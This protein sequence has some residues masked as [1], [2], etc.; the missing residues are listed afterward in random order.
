[1]EGLDL[2]WSHKRFPEEA[3]KLIHTFYVLYIIIGRCRSTGIDL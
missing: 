1:M 2:L 3:V